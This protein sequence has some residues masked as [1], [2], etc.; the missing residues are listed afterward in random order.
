MACIG[1]GGGLSLLW[2]KDVNLSILSYSQSHIDTHTL[3]DDALKNQWFITGIF[4]N[5]DASKRD[6][7]N[8][9]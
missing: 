8:G 5:L 4:G 2:K 6:A 3:D 7:P 1:H 9:K